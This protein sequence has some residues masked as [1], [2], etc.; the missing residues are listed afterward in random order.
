MEVGKAFWLATLS[1]P[2][3]LLPPSDP[4]QAPRLPA[5]RR[6]LYHRLCCRV[7]GVAHSGTFWY[8][9]GAHGH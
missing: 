5:G 8:P 1:S 4:E 2:T 3:V 7:R 9:C 6:L